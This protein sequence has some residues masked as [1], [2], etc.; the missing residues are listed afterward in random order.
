MVEVCIRGFS[1]RG[2][3]LLSAGHGP[4]SARGAGAQRDL[5]G[6]GPRGPHRVRAT[7][8]GLE[9]FFGPQSSCVEMLSEQVKTP[10]LEGE[11]YPNRLSRFEC[12]QK[13]RDFELPA[14]IHNTVLLSTQKS[15]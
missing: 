3:Q 12:S 10:R 13:F 6:L 8:A 14:Y 4:R 5:G 9:Q 7:A 11:D 15:T 1:P 2:A